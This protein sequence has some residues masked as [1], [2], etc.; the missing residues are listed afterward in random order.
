MSS[1]LSPLDLNYANAANNDLRP[2][3]EAIALDARNRLRPVG[4]PAGNPNHLLG[5]DV[6][7]IQSPARPNPA[8][9]SQQAPVAASENAADDDASVSL[10]IG[11]LAL[12]GTA[13]MYAYSYFFP[14]P[15]VATPV[16]APEARPPAVVHFAPTVIDRF[17]PLDADPR[18]LE[19][20]RLAHLTL[21]DAEIAQ[22]LADEEAQAA[23]LAAQQRQNQIRRDGTFANQLNGAQVA[24]VAELQQQNQAR[25]AESMAQQP[26]DLSAERKDN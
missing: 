23:A 2:M 25:Q 26:Q 13:G 4:Q 1:K 16:V 14:T 9:S 24:A 3:H 7:P 10:L 19:R 5:R 6:Q 21:N 12:A 11:G 8:A 20:I 18:D 17:N 15:S 22:R